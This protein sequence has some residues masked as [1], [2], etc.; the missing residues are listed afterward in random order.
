G[1]FATYPSNTYSWTPTAGQVSST[2][3]IQVAN[4]TQSITDDSDAVFTITV[5][6]V[7]EVTVLTPNGGEELN[8]GD[9][10]SITWNT[11][12]MEGSD[13][14]E[15]RLS[16]DGGESYTTI[17]DGTVEG[18]AGSY[19]W[20]VSDDAGINNYIQ[21][22][23]TT[24]GVSDE[25]DA[26]FS[27]LSNNITPV[28]FE[29]SNVSS[30]S[31]TANWSPLSGAVSYRLDVSE[32]SDFSTFLPSLEDAQVDE[33]SIV[34]S[35]LDFGQTYYYRVRAVDEESAVSDNSNV[36]QLKTFI[37]F[38]TN[39]DSLALLE[40][41]ASINPEGLNWETDRLRNWTNV[42]LDETRTRVAAVNLG[43]TNSIGEM[44]NLF[45]ATSGL[46]ALTEMDL[47]NN[48][49]TGLIEFSQTNV[50]TLDVSQNALEFDDL[51]PL[52]PIEIVEYS[53]QASIQFLEAQGDPIEVA[54]L[55]NS[56]LSIITGGTANEYRWF[57]N[58][59]EI[60]NGL[61]FFIERNELEILEIDF[62]S[63]GAFTAQVTNGLVPGLVIEIDPQIILA[64]AEVAI[65][66]VNSGGNTLSE[67]VSGY[68]LEAI[69]RGSGYDTLER[70]SQVT[71]T[72]TFQNVVLGDYLVNIDPV[73]DENF[74]ST[75]YT[76]AI[77]WEQADNLLLRNDTLITIAMEEIPPPLGDGDGDGSLEVLIEEDFGDENS[78]IDARRRAAKRKCG[79]RRKRS[80]GRVDQDDDEFELI[81]Y[82]ETDDNGEFKFGFLP[83]GTYRFFVEYPGI[84]LDA[85]SEVEFEV[86]EA[87]ISDTDF[88]LEAFASEDGISVSIERVLGVILEYF[89]DLKVYPNPSSEYLNISY[90]HLKSQ[91][92][93]AEIVD[94][95]GNSMWTQHMNDG[96]DGSLKID[97]S[98]F[99]H[100]FIS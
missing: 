20:T 80:G 58:G 97:V 18:L 38:E 50:Q 91:E 85:S 72:F 88:K 22:V 75:Y 92:V 95:S 39:Q 61:D 57:R 66:A 47:S 56:S 9:E 84:P 46:S 55:D 67:T 89:K 21:V 69:R 63:M 34:V 83:T 94:L 43:S 64:T 82:S 5:A 93:I 2:A 30:T 68:M 76:N 98:T 51:E 24:L 65:R 10:Y 35:G 99:E 17:D 27:I 8:I 90:R 77:E 37:D 15:I 44:P 1:T 74:I 53:D 79:L 100:E 13:A 40:I 48:L 16:K 54:H 11:R 28:A 6:L 26:A 41:Y 14:L 86:G 29:A 42:T 7:P 60:Q 96:F 12:D 70:V 32:A 81:A 49:I 73:S 59:D 62:N 36:I 4:T 19:T 3:L 78:R 71:G 23:N 33:A 45:V 87:G 31:F 52:A 25:S